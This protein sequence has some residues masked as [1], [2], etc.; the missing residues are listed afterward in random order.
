MNVLIQTVHFV[1]DEKLTQLVTQK[2]KKLHHFHDGI[3]KIEIFLKL[4]NVVHHIKDKVVEICVHV[5]KHD[6]FVKDSSK[7][8]EVA[9]ERAFDAMVAQ[10]K[11]H[12]EKLA[13]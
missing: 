1:A 12:K 2:A 4:D 9:F 7:T 10:I 13:A 8:F 11:K 5:P 6:F 3:T